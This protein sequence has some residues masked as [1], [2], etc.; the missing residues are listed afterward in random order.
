MTCSWA[1]LDHLPHPN[2][3]HFPQSTL[4]SPSQQPK[5]T[6]LSLHTYTFNMRLLTITYAVVAVLS[7]QVFAQLPDYS[8]YSYCNG[9]SPIANKTY[10]PLVCH[11]LTSKKQSA[12]TSTVSD[13][14]YLSRVKIGPN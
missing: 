11:S 3:S 7:S 14:Q 12:S 5:S 8:G 4:T 2:C 6:R 1:L 10:A 9:I 13:V